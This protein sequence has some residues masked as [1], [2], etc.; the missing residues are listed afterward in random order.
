M[1][2]STPT[3]PGQILTSAYVNNNIN[4]GLTYISTTSLT[5]S[6]QNIAGA[7]SS[8]Y[9]NY[10][11]VLN[12]I[13]TSATNSG[14]GF[15]LGSSTTRTEYKYGGQNV[16]IGSGVVTVDRDAASNYALL[17]YTKGVDGTNVTFIFDLIGPQTATRKMYSSQWSNGQYGGTLSGV[18]NLASAQTDI[19]FMV[20]SG[21]LTGGTVTIYGYRKA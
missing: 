16:N 2:V 5:S 7:F 4:S 15:R 20:T 6:G 10:R 17:G 12:E 3:T 13:V 14:L 11:I 1:A 21:T 8:T 9:T 18:D 19:N